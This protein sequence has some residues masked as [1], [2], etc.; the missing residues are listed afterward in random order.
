MPE[1]PSNALYGILA[2]FG[3]VSV[4]L[5]AVQF[6]NV[7]SPVNLVFSA[8]VTSLLASVLLPSKACEPMDVNWLKSSVLGKLAL[9]KA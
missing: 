7:C 5:R 1:Q 6:K 9:L 3:I 4:P 8:K 2:P